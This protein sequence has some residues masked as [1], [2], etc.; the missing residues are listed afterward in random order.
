[1]KVRELNKV[2][3]FK[4]EIRI[5]NIQDIYSLL[6]ERLN[7]KDLPMYYDELIENIESY[8]DKFNEIDY[9]CNNNN[10]PELRVRNLDFQDLV[11]LKITKDFI[12]YIGWEKNH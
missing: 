11:V 6:R 1:M 5:N 2:V 12:V 7:V 10:C 4:Y 9:I 8:I 3:D